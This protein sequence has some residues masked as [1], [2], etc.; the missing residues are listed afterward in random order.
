MFWVAQEVSNVPW[1]ITYSSPLHSDPPSTL[2]FLAYYHIKW[3]SFMDSFVYRFVFLIIIN[4]WEWE[5]GLCTLESQSL[6]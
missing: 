4:I 2:L 5:L 6:V 1:L 3:N